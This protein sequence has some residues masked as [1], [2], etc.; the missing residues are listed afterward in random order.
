M[1]RNRIRL[2]QGEEAFQN[3]KR[4]LR[5]W[6]MFATGWTE[7]CDPDTPIEPGATVAVVVSHY[8]FWSMNACRIVYVIDEPRTFGFAYGT[9]IEHAEAGEERFAVEIDPRDGAVWYDIYAISRPQLAARLA[10]PLA[11]RLQKRFA[12]DSRQAM[13]RAVEI[14]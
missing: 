3:A 2:G 4:A 12:E 11:R 9:L 14:P 7:L 10:R 6:R 13:R 8:G 1:E 5:S